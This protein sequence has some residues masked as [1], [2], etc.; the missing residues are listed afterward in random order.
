MLLRQLQQ[1]GLHFVEREVLIEA[2]ARTFT[3]VM[4]G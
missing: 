2:V 1:N 4:D 3:V